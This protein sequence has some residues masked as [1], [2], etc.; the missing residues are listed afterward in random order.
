MTVAYGVERSL[1]QKMSC[2][3]VL[4]ALIGLLVPLVFGAAAPKLIECSTQD[5][6]VLDQCCLKPIGN[7]AE[8]DMMVDCNP[9]KDKK[10]YSWINDYMLNTLQIFKKNNTINITDANTLKVLCSAATFVNCLFNKANLLDENND[11]KTDAAVGFLT[12]SRDDSD[13]W[14]KI[15]TDRIGNVQSLDEFVPARFESGIKCPGTTKGSTLNVTIEPLVLVQFLQM[16]VV[17]L[18]P[19]PKNFTKADKKCNNATLATWKN[20]TQPLMRTLYPSGGSPVS[21]QAVKVSSTDSKS[22]EAPPGKRNIF[23][24]IKSIVKETSNA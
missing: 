21:V 20:C 11:V 8:N 5:F 12:S 17:E 3:A 13:P 18:C 14:K 16:G 9:K 4:F 7:L 2:K 10:L 6:T 22:A 15:I 1:A 23:N 24:Y 19:Q